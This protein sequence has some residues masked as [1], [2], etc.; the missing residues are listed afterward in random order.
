MRTT[1]ACGI[2]F[3]RAGGPEPTRIRGT[4]MPV[5]V[6]TDSTSYIPTQTAEELGITV[7]SLGVVFGDEA[8]R[9]LD[10]EDRWFYEKMAASPK[11]PT[12]S[13]PSPAEMRAA[14][15]AGVLAGDPVVG[16]FIS[17]DMSGTLASAELVA[18][19]L[20]REHPGADI[21]IVD[22][23]SNSMQ[24][25][26][27]VIAAAKA[28]AAGQDAEDCVRAAE[29][30][31]LRTR[32]LFTPLTL[33]YLR[34]GGR[35]GGASALL[36]TLLQIRP[37][38]TVEEGRTQVFDKVRT[39]RRAFERI[40]EAFAADVAAAGLTDVAVHH[41]DDAAEGEMLAGMAEAVAG[42]EVPIITI[43]PVIG[44]HVGPGTAALVYRTRDPLR[45]AP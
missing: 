23:R 24:L 14:F 29:E 17:S 11:I 35:I 9:E 5:R 19:E 8:F 7:V 20:R 44:L 40:V 30:T 39:R 41:I 31:V 4:E 42:C 10:V 18:E 38:L 28:A 25:G 32:Y 43:G 15:E 34:K 6:V 16:V 22:S 36:G 33:D 2:V 3:V 37:I 12:S 1:F 27:A 45:S 21:R 26:F 13:Q